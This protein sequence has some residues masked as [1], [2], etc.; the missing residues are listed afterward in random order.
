[1]RRGTGGGGVYHSIFGI[2]GSRER[3]SKSIF[4]FGWFIV[5]L[6]LHNLFSAPYAYWVFTNINWLWGTRLEYLFTF[7][8]AFFFLSYMHLFNRRYLNPVIYYIA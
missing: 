6:A 3:N 4:V 1:M 8:A 7:I 5:F 2:R